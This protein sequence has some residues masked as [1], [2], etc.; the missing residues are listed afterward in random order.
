MTI[1]VR[2]WDRGQARPGTLARN[3]DAMHHTDYRAI[4]E[5]YRHLWAGTATLE[6]VALALEG[7]AASRETRHLSTPLARVCN[8]AMKHGSI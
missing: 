4:A 8:A 2:V 6:Q 7:V 3:G 1:S 5:D